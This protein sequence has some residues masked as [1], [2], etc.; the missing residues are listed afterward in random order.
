MRRGRLGRIDDGGITGHDAGEIGRRGAPAPEPAPRRKPVQHGEYEHTDQGGTHRSF[1]E[2]DQAL[3]VPID[4]PSCNGNHAAFLPVARQP[5][6]N[7]AHRCG[8]FGRL[9]DWSRM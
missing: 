2:L 4:W 6:G 5:P 8:L 9:R 3:F 7:L 1:L